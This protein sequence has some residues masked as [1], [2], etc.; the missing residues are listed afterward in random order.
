HSVRSG[1]RKSD[2]AVGGHV[3]SPAR[4]TFAHIGSK[5]LLEDAAS[6]QLC[7]SE[8]RAR[9]IETIERAI[10]AKARA[11]HR[12]RVLFAFSGVAAAAA[13]IFA[14]VRLSPL[15]NSLGSS[16]GSSLRS[17]LGSHAT[18]QISQSQLSSPA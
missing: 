18:A 11:R 4:Q 7:T 17:S 15:G 5:I 2:V 3:V 9:A 12:R 13:S 10:L 8:D 1:A 14:V 16:L 6:E